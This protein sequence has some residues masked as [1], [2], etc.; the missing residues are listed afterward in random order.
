[1]LRNVTL[2]FAALL[3][4]S[5]SLLASCWGDPTPAPNIAPVIHG[6]TVQGE[7]VDSLYLREGAR[8]S[9]TVVISDANGDEMNEDSFT[10]QAEL[11]TL[12]GF[13]PSVRYVPPTNIVWENPPQEVIDTIRVTVTD[14]QP[15]SEPA[16]ATLEVEIS[17]PCPAVNEEPIIHAITADPLEIDLGD[18]SVITVDAEDPEGAPLLYEWTPPFGYMEGAGS[19]VTWVSTDVCCDAWYSVEVVVSDG[20]TASWG[21][22][23]VHVTP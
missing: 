16:S 7:R 4:V 18:T 10:W 8:P 5:G 15:G 13:G 20:C 2:T 14:G 1:M 12:D 22:V 21:F 19:S 6:F 23:E 17:P 11:G 9:I 3:A